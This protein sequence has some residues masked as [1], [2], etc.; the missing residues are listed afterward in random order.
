MLTIDP[1]HNLFLGTGKHML[2]LWLDSGIIHKGQYLCI[3]TYVDQM[4]VPSDVGRISYEIVSG[5]SSFTADQFKNWIVSF[6]IPTLYGILPQ[7]HFQ[8]WHHFILA[9]RIICQLS[10][11]D[12]DL[13]DAL[14][15]RFCQRAQC[16]YGEHFITPN[17]HM[18]AHLKNAVEDYGPVFGFWLFSFEQYNGILGHQSTNHRDIESQLLN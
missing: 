9:C 18:N 16:L 10:Q 13:F 15:I 12:I 14:L 4:V 8:C 5:F 6:S 7:K 11:S 1:M 3:Q 2:Q 17:M